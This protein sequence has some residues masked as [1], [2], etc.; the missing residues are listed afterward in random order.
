MSRSS[1]Q[2]RR[3]RRLLAWVAL[4]LV[5]AGGAAMLWSS[6]RGPKLPPPPPVTAAPVV[7]AK[8]VGTDQFK[9]LPMPQREAYLRVLL[10]SIPELME[11]IRKGELTQDDVQRGITN[12]APLAADIQARDYLNLPTPAQRQA[13]LDAL[14]DQQE[15]LRWL[16]GLL[17]FGNSSSGGN[18]NGVPAAMYQPAQMKDFLEH[19][20]PLT[21]TRMAQFMGDMRQRRLERGLPPEPGIR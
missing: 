12:A 15:R 8:F 6:A 21:R 9:T 5:L 13:H 2:P 3:L 19:T 18:V 7:L 17:R 20:D 1:P 4:L 11:A 10:N 14:I 16:T